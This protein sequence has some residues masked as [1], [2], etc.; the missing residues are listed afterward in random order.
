MA[1]KALVI[2]AE[3]FEE[4]EAVTCID[5]LRRAGVQVTVAAANTHTTLTAIRGSR[6]ICV[7][8]ETHLVDAGEEFD[9][10]VLPGGMPGAANLAA[11]AHVNTLIASM[12]RR[13]KI[14]AA[15]CASPAVVLAPLGI[16]EGKSATCYPGM[17]NEF[18]AST[19]FLADPVVVDGTLITSRAPGTAIRFALTV[20]EK[21]VGAETARKVAAA[22]LA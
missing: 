10:L 22:M 14:I 16:L 6:G 4:I 9:A 15:I 1:K 19:R 11:T 2:L 7:M 18:A 5:V 12:A 17:E 21:L 8:P 20:A 3:G 13:N